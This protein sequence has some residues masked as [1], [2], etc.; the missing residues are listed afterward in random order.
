MGILRHGRRRED[1]FMAARVYS[2]TT[3]ANVKNER[4]ILVSVS[5]PIS[6]VI[7]EHLTSLV[8]LFILFE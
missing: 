5:D 4:R 3:S 7:S 6:T 8:K 2:Y 1:N